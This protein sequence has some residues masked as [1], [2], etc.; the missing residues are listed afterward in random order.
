MAQTMVM[1]CP[2][3]DSVLGTRERHGVVIEECPGCQGVFLDPGE[4]EQLINAGS[5]Y[6][7]ALPG[8]EN[9]DTT[10]RGRHRHA[11]IQVE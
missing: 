3:C 9:P 4:L 5:G 8:G 6:L 2:K 7:A 11:L 10:Y 1:H